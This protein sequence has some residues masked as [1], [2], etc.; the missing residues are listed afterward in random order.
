MFSS[1]FLVPLIP[2]FLVLGTGLLPPLA[3]RFIFR[4]RIKNRKSPLNMDLLRTPGES[5]R[6]ET[7]EIDD[8]IKVVLSDKQIR[9]I[10]FQIEKE[11]RTV[12]GQAY[13]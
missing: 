8:T 10:S 13:Q 5:L 7:D 12:R 3:I 6:K 9:M 1:E 2:A 11:C 4:Q